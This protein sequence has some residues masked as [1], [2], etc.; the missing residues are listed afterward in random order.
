[1]SRYSDRQP[2][3]IAADF[4]VTRPFTINGRTYDYGDT[5]VPDAIGHRLLRNLYDSRRIDIAPEGSLP[6]K[7]VATRT[8]AEIAAAGDADE[9]LVH[10]GFGKW[11]FTRE[12]GTV[13][14]AYR[15][16]AEAREAL[17]EY[18]AAL[19]AELAANDTPSGAAEEPAGGEP[20]P[21]ATDVLADPPA[22]AGEAPVPA[23][24]VQ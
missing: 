2:F 16:V 24:A 3:T 18:R 9:A 8:P 15:N 1:M 21:P 13:S 12:D 22:P 19:A 7:N 11:A 4:V 6:R 17:A 5:L 10:K 14:K 23:E 20:P